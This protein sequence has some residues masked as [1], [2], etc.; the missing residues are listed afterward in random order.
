MKVEIEKLENGYL[1]IQDNKTK[2]GINDENTLVDKLQLILKDYCNI[3]DKMYFNNV[4]KVKIIITI[5]DL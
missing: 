2:T 1:I 5:E 3:K 4:K